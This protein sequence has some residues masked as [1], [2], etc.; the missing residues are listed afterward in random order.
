MR[1]V[2]PVLTLVLLAG[3]GCNQILGIGD[4]GVAGID[5]PPGTADG[6]ID[7]GM[8]DAARVDCA[9]AFAC[10]PPNAS[11]ATLCGEL[12]DLE[13]GTLVTG[14]VAMPERCDPS[15]PAATGPCSMQ[16]TF[17][18]PSQYASNPAT[19]QPLTYD[20]LY[21]D[22]CGRFRATNV[23]V[24]GFGAVAITV[25][26]APGVTDTHRVTGIGVAVAN[27][28]AHEGLGVYAVRSSTD[29][30]WKTSAG[31]SGTQTFVDRGVYVAI[32]RYHGQPVGGVQVVR[33]GT[34]ITTGAF[35][36]GDPAA[37]LRNVD[38]SVSATGA[39]G[40]ALVIDDQSLLS[41]S[42]TQGNLVSGC[43]WPAVLGQSIPNT[44]V[45]QVFDAVEAGTT[46]P[47]P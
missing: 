15:N 29:Q 32:F 7:T 24:P 45:V 27:G 17:Y 42:G 35:Y 28:E 33:N 37:M 10:P 5:G 39:D 20:D 22:E 12:R 2:R 34:P 47:C 41:H 31:L 26:D 9:A 36:F 44:A 46:T 25:D 23:Q 3:A 30:Q 11:K 21:V 19:A 6:A 13:T 38:T 14:D 1:A 4:L 43:Q 8:P 16:L 18:D 40:A